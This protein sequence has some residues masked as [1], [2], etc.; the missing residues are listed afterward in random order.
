MEELQETIASI[1]RRLSVV[2]QLL[3]YQIIEG[4]KLAEAAPILKRLG[5]TN[6]RLAKYSTLPQTSSGLD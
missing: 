1:D 2:V 5:L 4:K 6:V 3:A